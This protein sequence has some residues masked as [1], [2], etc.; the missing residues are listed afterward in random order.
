MWHTTTDLYKNIIKICI[1]V[2]NCLGFYLANH[3]QFDCS[4]S[5]Q[6]VSKKQ[7]N[8]KNQPETSLSDDASSHAVNVGARRDAGDPDAIDSQLSDN[9]PLQ[10]VNSKLRSDEQSLQ[11]LDESLSFSSEMTAENVN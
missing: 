6:K 8:V 2:C 11:L 1:L 7:I 3:F 10:S 5:I 4:Y 9:L